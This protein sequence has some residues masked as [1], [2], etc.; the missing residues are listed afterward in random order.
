MRSTTTYEFGDILLVEFPRTDGSGTTRRPGLVLLDEGDRD[1]MVAR[2]TTQT[3]RGNADIVL[4]DWDEAGL[5][6][7]SVARLGKVATIEKSSVSRPL[8]RLTVGET[9]RVRRTWVSLFRCAVD[10]G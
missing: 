7:R 4:A 5:L 9:A 2:V 8:G 1:V 3:P 10:D 6:A